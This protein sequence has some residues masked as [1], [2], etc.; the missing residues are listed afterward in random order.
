MSRLG[1]PPAPPR[2]LPARAISLSIAA[3]M[4]TTPGCEH[5]LVTP[6]QY[7][8]L[9][10]SVTMGSGAPVTDLGLVLYTGV[11]PIEYSATDA[12]GSH[13]F[14]RVP[15][16]NYGVTGPMPMGMCD[17]HESSILVKDD[18][19]MGPGS[20]RVVTFILHACV[21]PRPNRF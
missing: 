7:G 10:V 5:M 14:E 11:R 8:E 19:D 17:E 20:E 9:R 1:P 15:P 6:S 16:G 18:L 4:L 2:V 12:S 13:T 21:G 3:L